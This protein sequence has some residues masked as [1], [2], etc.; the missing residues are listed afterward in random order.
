VIDAFFVAEYTQRS[1]P[2]KCL[3]RTTSAF[4]DIPQAHPK[5]YIGAIIAL[6]TLMAHSESKF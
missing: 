5:A 3:S 2:G 6:S 1:S 4:R